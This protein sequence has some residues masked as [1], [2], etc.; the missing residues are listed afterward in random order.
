MATSRIHPRNSVDEGKNAMLD[1][2]TVSRNV[3]SVPS[4]SCWLCF[5]SFKNFG[6]AW[7]VRKSK[8]EKIAKVSF[9]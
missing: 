3:N 1:I 5:L 9:I 2:L 7:V 6:P 4:N 8:K